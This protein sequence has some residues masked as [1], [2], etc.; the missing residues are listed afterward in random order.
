MR[1]DGDEWGTGQDLGKA[2]IDDGAGIE[3]GR[4]ENPGS[5][6]E[7]FPQQASGK[8][9]EAEAEQWCEQLIREGQ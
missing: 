4:G 6:A 9:Q 2:L 3:G 8:D 7:G 5:W 1:L